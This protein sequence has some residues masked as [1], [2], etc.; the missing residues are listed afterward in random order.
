LQEIDLDRRNDAYVSS[1]DNEGTQFDDANNIQI[2]PDEDVYAG[3][4]EGEDSNP[5][6]IEGAFICIYFMYIYIYI[7]CILYICIQIYTHMHIYVYI[8]INIYIYAYIYIYIY[9]C[10]YIYTYRGGGVRA[11][12]Q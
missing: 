1:H 11:S 5:D 8:Y 7:L 12:Y 2:V 6:Y 10:T 4:G 9:I 3:D